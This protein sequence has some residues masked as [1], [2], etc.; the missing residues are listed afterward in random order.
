M[1]EENIGG[2]NEAR[3]RCI[4]RNKILFEGYVHG[5]HYLSADFHTGA[6]FDI[7]CKLKRKRLG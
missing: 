4:L 6:A 1:Y 5:E 7:I 3:L 2:N